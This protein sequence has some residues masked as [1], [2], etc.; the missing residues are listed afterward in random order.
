MAPGVNGDLVYVSTVP[1]NPDGFYTGDGQGI[2][3]ALN[4]ETGEKVWQFETVPAELWGN[5]KINSG[6]GLWHPPS[7]DDQGGDVHRH[8]QPGAVPRHQGAARGPR[9]ARA[10]T[11]TPTPS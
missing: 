4:A 5:K 6:G 1:G 7:F 10:R 2:V 11:R 9:A 8:R 3:H